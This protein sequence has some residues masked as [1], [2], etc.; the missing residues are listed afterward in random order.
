M[1]LIGD[2]KQAIYSFRGADVFAYLRAARD[3]RG[4]SATLDT[5][6]RS[7]PSL[8]RAV[9]TVFAR[10]T[11]PFLLDDI[12]FAP[13]K[14][15]PDATERLQ[16]GGASASK[17]RILF[18]RREPGATAPI[19]K[20]WADRHLPDAI[21]A[22]IARLLRS[23]ATIDGRAVS[24][25]DVAVLVRKNRQAVA[26]QAALRELRVPSVLQGDASVFDAPEALEVQQIMAALV[27]PARGGAV[28]LALATGLLGLDARRDPRPRGRRRRLGSL[29][30]VLSSV[31]Q[32]LGGS[33]LRRRVPAAPRPARRRAAPPAP[34]RRRAA[35]HQRAP[36]RRAAPHG[37][38]APAPRTGRAPPLARGDAARPRGPRSLR[39]RG[40]A[41]AAGE[42][43]P[44]REALHDP[45]EQG[46]PVPDRVLPPPVGRQ[47]ARPGRRGRAALPRSGERS[48]PHARPRL[49][50]RRRAPPPRRA[51]GRGRE[52]APP[53][54]RAHARQAPGRRRLGQLQGRGDIAARLPA[55][56]AAGPERRSLRGHA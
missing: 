38:I 20:G 56:P 53:L 6:H 13:V 11:A 24:A 32:A 36:P 14:P 23:G 29:D 16:D 48:A 40:R 1:F 17:L 9:N 43:R 42:R 51:R 31:G 10:A 41:G 2:P 25:G 37:V 44:R 45:Q 12:A 28:R 5:N 34:R 21:A 22:D 19:A 49:A 50:R 26:V 52:P 8:V 27:T 46:A 7:D 18:A 3:A 33:R 39:G 35:A 47:A 30:P 4:H 54:R 55:P 15:A